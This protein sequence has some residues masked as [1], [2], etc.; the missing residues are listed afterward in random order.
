VAWFAGGSRRVLVDVRDAW[1][2]LRH[3]RSAT[4]LALGVLTLT[5]TVTTV[6]F[7]VV[8]GTVLRPLPYGD[9]ERLISLA[10]P[11][12]TAGLFMPPSPSDYLDWR[13]QGQTLAGIAA[14][15]PAG[16]LPL[17]VDGTSEDVVVRRVTPNLFDVLRVHA[18]MGRLFGP[19]DATAPV[20]VVGH[21]FWTSRLAADPAVVG[22]RI[23]LNHQPV[24]IVGV[25]PEG[26]AYPVAMRADELYIPYVPPAPGTRESTLCCLSVVARLKPDVTFEQARADLE[27]ISS[28]TV[29]RGLRD[30]AIGKSKVWLLFLLAA[31]GIVVV[32][33]S[34]NV[35]G[36]MFARA[37]TRLP[38][39]A[40]REA[41]GA[42]R[43]RI[44]GV[45]LVE[46]AIVAVTAALLA[47]IPSLWGIAIAKTN[48][49]PDVRRAAD[50]AITGR[51]L[52]VTLGAGAV[53]GLF[54][55]GAPAWLAVRH[56]TAWL[57]GPAT[58]AGQ[59]RGRRRVLSGLLTVDVAFV[60][61]L[62]VAASLV[63]TSFV[64]IATMDLGF[65]RE[66]VMEVEFQRSLTNVPPQER[67]V[68]AKT[69]RAELIE[70]AM[71]V[72]G[73]EDAAI[74]FGAEPLSGSRIGLDVSLPG[75]APSSVDRPIET[76]EVTQGY[77]D[78]MGIRP[79]R[80]RLFRSSDE[81]SAPVVILSDVAARRLFPE[82]DALGR[83]VVVHANPSVAMTVVGIVRALPGSSVV[84][85][86]DPE[87]YILLAHDP[88]RQSARFEV[89]WETLVVRTTG[90]PRRTEQGVRDSMQRVLGQAPGHTLYLA[91]F[92]ERSTVDRRFAAGI[93][94]AFGLLALATGVIGIYGT[95]AFLVARQSRS[96]GIRL[97][98]GASRGR[99]LR[100][101]LAWAL[102]PVGLGLLVG[103]LGAWAMSGTFAALLF[104][105]QPADPRV[106]T[107]VAVCLLLIGVA[108]GLVPAWRASRIDPIAVLKQE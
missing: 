25:L 87:I 59:D 9:S 55:A 30:S 48:L 14:E 11:G 33:A 47:L 94:G 105:V 46:G 95:I 67:P 84:A 7:A 4:L 50:I 42:S 103:L 10:F 101:T 57:T 82:R 64:I 44:A 17:E 51:V 98:L 49:P 38:E 3:G 56:G 12:P 65:D 75:A 16:S 37:V 41:L 72:R 35:S 24:T 52:L 77:F 2:G 8:D 74:L 32:I 99:I 60:S 73:V 66:H 79:V 76:R 69:L 29:V 96:I 107:A 53:C 97:A 86:P 58:V 34:V 15:R 68:A 6:T 63:V 20:A 93:L 5:M 100:W 39:L 90:D 80:G 54:V 81:T 71:T 28:S 45:L 85:P 104:R 108:A 40:V 13:D 62:L 26:I 83:T 102:R 19:D 18:A 1:R 78:V 36:V 61:T 27:R 22:R 31:V 91:D 23:R 89:M 43:R 88:Y 70:S 21:A 106:Y 92:F